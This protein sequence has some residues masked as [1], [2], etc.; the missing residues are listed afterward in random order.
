[1]SAKEVLRGLWGSAE[2]AL[3]DLNAQ[4]SPTRTCRN[5]QDVNFDG[6]AE[7]GEDPREAWRALLAREGKLVPHSGA[8]PAGS[9]AG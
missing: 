8:L 4:C 5:M 3:E 1:M 9:E 2:G 6:Y 7:G